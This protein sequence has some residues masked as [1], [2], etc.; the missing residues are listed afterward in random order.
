MSFVVG[1]TIG[2]VYMWTHKVLSYS[3][4]FVASLVILPIIVALM[5][6]LRCATDG[7]F[8]TRKRKLGGWEGERVKQESSKLRSGK[9]GKPG[10]LKAK[11]KLKRGKNSAA[12]KAMGDKKLNL[13]NNPDNPCRSV[14]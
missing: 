4:T 10:S 3:Q 11:Q 9:A 12:L 14:S 6:S 7:L 13:N 5:M 2:W 1:Q 8:R